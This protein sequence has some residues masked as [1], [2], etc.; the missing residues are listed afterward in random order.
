MSGLGQ[1][2]AFMV[3][4][5]SLSKT[6]HFSIHLCL[7]IMTKGTP[8]S[9]VRTIWLSSFLRFCRTFLSSSMILVNKGLSLVVNSEDTLW[10][11]HSIQYSH[12]FCR[13]LF[14]PIESQ[15][16]FALVNYGRGG[17]G[18]GKFFT[19]LEHGLLSALVKGLLKSCKPICP[20]VCNCL[21]PWRK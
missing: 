7:S 16:C 11:W 15:I 4:F 3:Y 9:A 5:L 10:V 20:S 12:F 18:D 21:V 19:F 8:L 2:S 1:V 13:G 6:M 14:S 17:W